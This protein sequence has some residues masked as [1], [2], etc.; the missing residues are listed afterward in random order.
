VGV[1]KN[2]RRGLRKY[3]SHIRF[4]V[5]DSSEIRSWHDK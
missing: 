3:F 2:I 4:E 1:Q 5:G